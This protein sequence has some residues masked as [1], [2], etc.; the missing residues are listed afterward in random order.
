MLEHNQLR[1]PSGKII[2]FNN[3][4]IEGLDKILKWLKTPA[5]EQRFFTLMGYAGTGKTTIIKK[6]LD[7]YRRGVAVSAPTHKAKKVIMKTTGRDGQT[8]HGL[9]GLRPDVD[10]DNFNPNNPKFNPIAVPKIGDY[11]FVII[12]EASMINKELYDL[13]IDKTDNTNTKILFMGDP[14][15]I[16][17]V[18]EKESI[19]FK[20][21]NIERHELTKIE[22][23]NDTNPITFIYTDLRNNLNKINGGFE[24]KTNIIIVDDIEEGIIF[25]TDKKVFR[26]KIFKAFESEEF[27]KNIDHVKVIAWKNKTVIQANQIIRKRLQGK[28][29]DIIEV[30]DVIMGYRSI[31][32]ETRMVNIIENSADYR[33]VEKE[34]LSEN[35]F[36]IKGFKVK[37]RE[38]LNKGEY[39]FI[40]VF[41]VNTRDNE[42]RELYAQMHDFFRDMGKMNKKDWKKYYNFRR[43]NLIMEKIDTYRDGSYRQIFDVIVK[44]IDYG[45]AITGHKS[46]GS[47]YDQV[48]VME[49]DINDN[50]S[51]IER[52]RIKYVAFTRPKYIATILTTNLN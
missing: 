39:K 19:V 44:D 20:Q 26:E 21:D 12:D 36:S 5:K 35:S 50:W 3:E 15:Q 38:D 48:F 7:S 33:V 23:Q 18:G 42:N 13:I 8:L 31:T 25:T 11:N 24:R 34:G 6:V 1:L 52:N 10:L 30:G 4:Q 45:F 47:T 32:D 46:Q 37:I 2:V 43:H 14:A 28:D 49:N 27:K 22:R 9:L 41:I 29:A 51:L 40:D 16:P 17:P